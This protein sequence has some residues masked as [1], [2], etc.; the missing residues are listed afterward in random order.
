MNP[1]KSRIFFESENLYSNLYSGKTGFPGLQIFPQ[2]SQVQQGHKELVGKK[3][4]Q[5]PFDACL[6]D[7][8]QDKDNPDHDACQVVEET[9]AGLPQAVQDTVERSVQVQ[10]GADP[11]QRDDKVAGHFT[12]EKEGAQIFSEEKIFLIKLLVV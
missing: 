11:G 10:E 8:K 1:E 7:K 12:F 6:G 9:G 5:V 2:S 3:P 4:P